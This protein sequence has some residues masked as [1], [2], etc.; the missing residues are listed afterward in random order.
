MW[1][2]E[3]AYY[4]WLSINTTVIWKQGSEELYNQTQ[5]DGLQLGLNAPFSGIDGE[6][7]NPNI[8]N[9]ISNEQLYE[10]R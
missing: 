1:H 6:I 7:P 2:R 3:S 10:K 5:F 8:S 9:P 4:D